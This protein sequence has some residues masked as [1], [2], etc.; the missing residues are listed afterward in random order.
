MKENKIINIQNAVI[1]NGIIL[2]SIDKYRKEEKDGFSIWGGIEEIH[3]ENKTTKLDKDI[4]PLYLT[5]KDTIDTIMDKLL[6]ATVENNIY[7]YK[8]MK[9]L[10]VL[11]LENIISSSKKESDNKVK[12]SPIHVYIAKILLKQ[13][14]I[15]K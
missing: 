5:T 9:D 2:C 8:F 15:N 14:W 4:T 13:R 6:W 12:I 7:T 1:V 11:H 10:T 3:I